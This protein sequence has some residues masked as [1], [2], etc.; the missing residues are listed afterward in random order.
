MKIK[1]SA[2]GYLFTG[3]KGLKK[4]IRITFYR[5][6]CTHKKA[7]FHLIKNNVD[8]GVTFVCPD[9]R[10]SWAGDIRA[11]FSGKKYFLNRLASTR[12]QYSGDY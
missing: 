8:V 3:V 12:K 1:I 7:R 4:F 6:R 9:C 2:Y 5:I 10:R 11:G